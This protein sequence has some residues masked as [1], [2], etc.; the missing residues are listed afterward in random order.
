MSWRYVTPINPSGWWP[1][2]RHEMETFPRDW[3]FGRPIHQSLVDSPHNG[4][5]RGA[6]MFS[7][8]CAWTN[9]WTNNR[10]TGDLR[11]HCAYYDVTVI[12]KRLSSFDSLFMPTAKITSKFLIAD[13]HLKGEPNG[14]HELFKVLPSSYIPWHPGPLFTKRTDV[15]PRDSSLN[16]VLKF[17]S[18]VNRGPEVI[19]ANYLVKTIRYRWERLNT[20]AAFL[21][22]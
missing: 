14:Q 15:L 4:Q 10:D 7:F 17:N 2:W 22:T 12:H 21:W 13:C 11:R 6:L 20:T 9:G 5:W 19:W 8:F 1:W 3:P 16:F 18:L